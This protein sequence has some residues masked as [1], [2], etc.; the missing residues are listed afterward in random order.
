MCDWL[1]L[2]QC[3]NNTSRFNEG[4]SDNGLQAEGIGTGNVIGT[5]W[6]CHLRLREGLSL[7]RWN[8]VF[9]Q[10]KLAL[11]QNGFFFLKV[12]RGQFV[13]LIM[14]FV[15]GSGRLCHLYRRIWHWHI[16]GLSRE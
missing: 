4:A 15:I 3:A 11:A 1:S 2:W 14:K 5:G 8:L 13:T 16:E 10:G 7:V 9:T 12:G 6:V